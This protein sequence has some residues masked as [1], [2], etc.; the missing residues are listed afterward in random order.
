VTIV[1]RAPAVRSGGY[2]ID[3]RGTA[4]NVVERMGVLSQLRAAHIDTQRLRFVDAERNTIATIAPEKL[5]GGVAGHDIELP[6]GALTSVLYDL[7]RKGKVRYRFDDY[8]DACWRT[9]ALG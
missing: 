4:L 6:R 2:P 1:E 7:T 8:I 3:I 9:M 5:V